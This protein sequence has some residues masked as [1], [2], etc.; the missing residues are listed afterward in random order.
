MDYNIVLIIASAVLV[1]IGAIRNGIGAAKIK[2]ASDAGK[3]DEVSERRLGA[4][5]TSHAS[6]LGYILV[7]VAALLSQNWLILI[8]L[9]VFYI[10]DLVIMQVVASIKVHSVEKDWE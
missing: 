5:A 4:V 9:P 7:V 8:W 6:I 3:L 2:V 10:A 1:L